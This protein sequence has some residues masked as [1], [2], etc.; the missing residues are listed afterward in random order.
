MTSQHIS[1]TTEADAVSEAERFRKLAE[2]ARQMAE[3]AS[4]EEFK[5]FWLRTADDWL[6]L[7]KLVAW[8][9]SDQKD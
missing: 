1:K 4:S 8:E 2:E 3:R 6:R 7:A 9:G 5:A